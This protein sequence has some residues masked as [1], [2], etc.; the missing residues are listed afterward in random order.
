V[1][2]EIQPEAKQ[3]VEQTE[4]NLRAKVKDGRNYCHKN[5]LQAVRLVPSQ[6]KRNYVDT[7][8]GDARALQSSGLEPHHVLRKVHVFI[9]YLICATIFPLFRLTAEMLYPVR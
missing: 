3:G 5:I 9:Q 4:C 2:E 1:K 6:P 7:K 8:K